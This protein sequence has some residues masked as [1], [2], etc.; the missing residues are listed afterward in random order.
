MRSA[1][2]DLIGNNNCKDS[3]GQTTFVTFERGIMLNPRACIRFIAALSLGLRLAATPDAWGADHQHVLYSFGSQKDGSCPQSKLLVDRSDNLYGTTYLGGTENV[4]TVFQLTKNSDSR[5]SES[6]LH[7]FTESSKDGEYP[8]AGLIS[9]ASGNLYGTTF[10]GGNGP[11]FGGCGT[12]FELAEKTNGKWEEKVL[13][14]FS[15]VDGWAPQGALTTDA[16]G[17]LYGTTETGGAFFGGTVFA[18][19][20]TSNGGLSETVLYS[21]RRSGGD[22]DGPFSRLIF[23]AVGNLYGT[24][25]NGGAYGLGTVFRLRHV[26][27]GR[28]AETVLHSFKGSDGAYDLNG[29]TFDSSGNLYGAIPEQGPHGLG[30][31]FKLTHGRDGR[32][33][34]TVLWSFPLLGNGGY[35]AGDLVWDTLG[36]L[37]GVT[38]A[39]GNTKACQGGCG[40]I[41]KLSPSRNGK[42]THTV[43]HRFDGI[44]GN[45]PEA[46]LI[47]DAAGN[48]Y[49]TT[50]WGGAAGAGVVYQITP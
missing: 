43:L 46:G 21:F 27:G 32:W 41:F 42:W 9:D 40:T 29:L 16:F 15:G 44:D 19:A 22:G 25:Y 48:L 23:D 28:W 5:W 4:G 11:C 2:V 18:L 34:E 8:T 30:A 39:G 45:N 38:A 14:D 1:M 24:T 10:L 35:P 36:N 3:N 13:H 31:V 33:K 26:A 20:K 50:C 7:S 37:Y 49:G 6:L 12:V 47:W 17:T